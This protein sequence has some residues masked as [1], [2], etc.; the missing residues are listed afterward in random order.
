MLTRRLATAA[1]LLA[2]FGAACASHGGATVA[3]GAGSPSASTQSAAAVV[4]SSTTAPTLPPTTTAPPIA[5][6]PTPA[7]AKPVVKAPVTPEPASIEVDY[8]P[9][10]GATAT[11]TLVGPN[12]SHVQSL[13][14]GAAVFSGLPSG[15]YAITVTIDTPSGDPNIGDARQIINGNNVHVE[16]GDHGVIT[17]TDEGCAGAL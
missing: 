3:A 6:A 11:A 15:T 4:T 9:H 5:I 17:C 10:D 7:S 1:V 16:P 8:Q 13:D 12:G 14:S 2:L